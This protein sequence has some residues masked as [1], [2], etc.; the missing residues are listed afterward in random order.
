MSRTA[1]DW[2][3]G[4]SVWDNYERNLLPTVFEPLARELLDLA[5][6]AASEQGLDLGTR[7][8]IVARRAVEHV[9]PSGRGSSASTSAATSSPWRSPTRLI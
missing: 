7:T 2:N 4:T 5:H 9:G 1:L 8:G 6:R 3:P